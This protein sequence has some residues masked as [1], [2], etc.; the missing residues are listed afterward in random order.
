MGRRRIPEHLKR[1]SSEY[2]QLAFRVSKTDKAKLLRLAAEVAKLLN[3][4]RAKEDP[5]ITKGDAFVKALYFG[6][7]E[8]KK[9]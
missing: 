5:F 8:L 3:R 2:P 6:F 9:K 7:E 1:K 4:E